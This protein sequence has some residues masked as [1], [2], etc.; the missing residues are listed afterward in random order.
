MDDLNLPGVRR[1]ETIHH[2]TEGGPTTT[3]QAEQVCQRPACCGRMTVHSR[4]LKRMPDTPVN[5]G[6][7]VL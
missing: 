7:C 4:W 6:P 3:I 5:G 1:T 2:S